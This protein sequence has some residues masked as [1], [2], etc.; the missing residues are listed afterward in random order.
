MTVHLRRTSALAAV[1]LA[2]LVVPLAPATQALAEVAGCG[3]G[4]DNETGVLDLDLDG[5]LDTVVGLPDRTVNGQAA[6]GAIV[7]RQSS[8]GTAVLTRESLGLGAAQAGDRLG[9]VIN[10]VG[11]CPTLLVTAPGMGT[12][13]AVIRVLPSSEGL[14]GGARSL[15]LMP[16]L[17]ADARFGESMSWT[18]VRD[19]ASRSAHFLVGAPRADVN[20][21]RDAGAVHRVQVPNATD[22]AP[23]LGAALSFAS[24]GVP[25]KPK[26]G[27]R[28]G[29]VLT[30]TGIGVPRRDVAGRKN[31][32]V[33]LEQ[34]TSGG[35]RM[36]QQGRAGVPGPPRAGNRFGA[37]LV[38]THV[39]GAPGAKVAGKDDAGAVFV[40]NR[41]RWVTLR[42]GGLAAGSPARGD[43]F[44][45]ALMIGP[46]HDSRGLLFIGVP[47]DDTQRRKDVG[48]VVTYPL[49]VIG[50]GKRRGK[51]VRLSGADAG[52]RTG[53]TFSLR[54][55]ADSNER[56]DVLAGV[57]GLD[58]DGVTDAGGLL[59]VGGCFLGRC[60][61][62]ATLE[63]LGEMPQS[64]D[65][66]GSGTARSAT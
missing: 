49:D 27:D 53:S 7:V 42:Q 59:V 5:A 32:G 3:A 61:G 54:A 62:R 51:V 39:V 56:S 2:A 14:S 23:V 55:A 9:H 37:A 13:G 66:L 31:A 33:V 41:K 47:G 16:E 1:A 40:K 6:A 36:L 8:K 26:A 64:G 43:A 44:G 20:G 11:T 45:A 52:A 18:W 15:A 57:P 21:A 24:A 30:P 48:A 38:G 12:S 50:K 19:D 63:N 35:Y 46:G 28:F 58:G 4:Y 29:E 25:G 22:A 34:R 60:S 65:R 10:Q 17:G